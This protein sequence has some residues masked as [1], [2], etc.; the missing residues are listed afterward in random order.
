MIGAKPDQSAWH[1]H[2][3]DMIPAHAVRDD[4]GHFPRFMMI[5]PK[6]DVPE[7]HRPNDQAQSNGEVRMGNQ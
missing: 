2:D 7:S 6:V 5:L 4:S 1:L 3:T